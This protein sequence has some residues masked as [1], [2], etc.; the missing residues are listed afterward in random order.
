MITI[1]N[2]FNLHRTGCHSISF[3]VV[4]ASFM[5]GFADVI[6]DVGRDVVSVIADGFPL[7]VACF[8]FATLTPAYVIAPLIVKA[9]SIAIVTTHIATLK[10][11]FIEKL[12]A[13]KEHSF[14]FCMSVAMFYMFCLMFSSAIALLAYWFELS[15]ALSSI[16]ADTEVESGLWGLVKH[17][18]DLFMNLGCD[19]VFVLSLLFCF[20]RKP[21]M[22]ALHPVY[23][24]LQTY[25]D[26]FAGW[27]SICYGFIF[28]PLVMMNHSLTGVAHL[29]S[30]GILDVLM[31]SYIISAFCICNGGLFKRI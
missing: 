28:A 9:L 12:S 24:G 22:K 27:G 4:L 14:N 23:F 15:N 18:F 16:L 21:G 2:A 20:F 29:V 10:Q 11:P 17:W 31:V 6:R 1:K 30:Q 5:F 8:F 19:F 25:K 3:M 26:S 7:G 13:F